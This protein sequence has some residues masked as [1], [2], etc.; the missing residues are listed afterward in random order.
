M[1]RKTPHGGSPP[2]GNVEKFGFHPLFSQADQVKPGIFQV[3]SFTY[4]HFPQPFP[5]IS[6]GEFLSNFVNPPF[7][8]K[9]L[10]FYRA[11]HRNLQKWMNLYAPNSMQSQLKSENAGSNIRS[12][13]FVFTAFRPE[14]IWWRR[15]SVPSQQCGPPGIRST[16]GRQS[17]RRCRRRASA[18]AGR[19]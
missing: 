6:P 5:Q 1:S 14:W 18:A 16:P 4:A 7:M 3:Y 13:I 2:W 9:V 15:R 12:C 11:F 19:P 10:H 17:W 8:T